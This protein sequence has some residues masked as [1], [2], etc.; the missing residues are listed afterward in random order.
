MYSYLFEKCRN[1]GRPWST[2]QFSFD[3]LIRLSA[4]SFPLIII[5]ETRP[6]KHARIF[7]SLDGNISKI[8]FQRRLARRDVLIFRGVGTGDACD[9]AE[10]DV[11][12][13]SSRVIR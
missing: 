2:K 12:A 13:P 9:G 6:E 7:T 5:R 10:A 11:D 1:L 8:N 3:Q 4:S